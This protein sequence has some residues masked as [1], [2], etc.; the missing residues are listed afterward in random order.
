M[1]AG[2]PVVSFEGSAKN[3]EH[4]K[5]GWVVENA[6]IQ[7]LARGVIHLLDNQ[8]LAQK[9]GEKAAKFAVSEYSW[10]KL[11]EKVE[12]VYRNLLKRIGQ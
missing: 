2:K 4:G 10:A 8:E 5:T 7:D 12:V 1:A 9:I 6:N 11:A 3:I